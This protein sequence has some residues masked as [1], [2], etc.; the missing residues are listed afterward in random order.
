MLLD[1][2]E[3]GVDDLEAA[4]AAY[5]LLPG[6]APSRRPGGTLRFQLGRGAVELAAGSPGQHAL[7]FAIEPTV[8]LEA[9]PAHEPTPTGKAPLRRRRVL[10]RSPPA[11]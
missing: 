6:L 2:V 5:M 11:G 7:R 3:L 8:A 10:T 9:V 4:S 1:G